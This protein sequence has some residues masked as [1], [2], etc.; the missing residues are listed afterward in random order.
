MRELMEDQDYK[1]PDFLILIIIKFPNKIKAFLFEKN[2][3]LH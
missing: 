1:Y 3:D 2:T